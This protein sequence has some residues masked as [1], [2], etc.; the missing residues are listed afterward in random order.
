MGFFRSFALIVLLCSC[1]AVS[2][3]NTNLKGFTPTQK[4][5][6]L[7]PE[8]TKEL[9]SEAS[10]N[11]FY[12]QGVGDTAIKTTAAV[13]FPPYA[14]ALLGNSI[15]GLSGYEKIGIGDI[16]PG[17]VGR[18]LEKGYNEV[19]SAPGRLTSAVGG[20]KYRTRSDIRKRMEKYLKLVEK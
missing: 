17:A 14:I 7:T 5:K 11:W 3:S 20:E 10:G 16:V 15:L 4:Q 1:T 8:Q 19:S 9:L 18:G 2:N 13:L 6:V 12:G